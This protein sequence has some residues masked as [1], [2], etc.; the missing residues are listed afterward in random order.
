MMENGGVL[1]DIM[2]G[3]QRHL[4]TFIFHR[5]APVMFGSLKNHDLLNPPSISPS[6]VFASRTD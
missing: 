5:C 2:R 4:V 3:S 6:F 1:F